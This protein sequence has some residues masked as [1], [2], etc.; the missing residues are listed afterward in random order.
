MSKTDHTERDHLIIM[1]NQ[2][3]DNVGY[4]LSTEQVAEKVA[5]HITRFWAP[6]MRDRISVYVAEDGSALNEPARAAIEIM[7]QET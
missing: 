1:A 7:A 4:G 5:H 2:I 6:S 3:A